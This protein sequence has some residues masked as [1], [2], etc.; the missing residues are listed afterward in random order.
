MKLVTLSA[1][2]GEVERVYF[3]QVYKKQDGHGFPLPRGQASR[4]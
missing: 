1:A 4:E 3:F 2:E